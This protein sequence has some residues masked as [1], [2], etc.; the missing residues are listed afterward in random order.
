MTE[1]IIAPDETIVDETITTPPP[2]ATG[3]KIFTQADFDK[4]LGVR[5]SRE[6]VTSQ[7]AVETEKAKYVTVQSI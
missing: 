1:K 2:A 7:K 5:L 4:F 6:K 3:D